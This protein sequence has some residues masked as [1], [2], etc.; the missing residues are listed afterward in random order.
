M[1]YGARGAERIGDKRNA[2]TSPNDNQ[3]GN[4]SGKETQVRGKVIDIVG[5][6]D[7]SEN[8]GGGENANEML[9]YTQKE[10]PGYGQSD[11]NGN[12]SSARNRVGVS[13]FEATM[14]SWVVYPA[15]A[16]IE[17]NNQRSEEGG[18]NKG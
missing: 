8:E 3:S 2:D 1:D 15:P 10:E 13:V 14:F 4:G 6:T 5:Y 12:T 9:V 11:K 16:A 17:A 7:K 18:E